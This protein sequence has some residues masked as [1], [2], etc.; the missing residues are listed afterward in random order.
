MRVLL[1]SDID[2]VGRRGDIVDVSGGFARNYLVPTGRAVQAPPGVD[3]QAEAM[4]RARDLRDVKDR[5]SATTVAG[6]LSSKPVVIQARSGTEGRL[7]GSVTASDV[8]EAISSQLGATVDRRRIALEEP[9]RS[10]GTHTVHVRL[11]PEV[12]AEVVVEVAPIG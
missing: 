10:V 3:K 11:H 1:R 5:D 8:A 7:F 9:I 6:V 4:R 2:G 12:E